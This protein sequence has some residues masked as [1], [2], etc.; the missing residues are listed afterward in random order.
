MV[1]FNASLGGDFME[2]SKLFIYVV[3]S[4]TAELGLLNF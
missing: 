3:K 1:V 4:F 2:E